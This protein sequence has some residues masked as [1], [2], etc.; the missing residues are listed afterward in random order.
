M[1]ESN[2]YKQGITAS[3]IP[4][5]RLYVPKFPQITGHMRFMTVGCIWKPL[6]E[7]AAG[8]QL[9]S[10]NYFQSVHG[11]TQLYRSRSHSLK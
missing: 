2:I 8:G 7:K 6:I 9:F 11:Y 3:E 5:S 1:M 4:L 10:N